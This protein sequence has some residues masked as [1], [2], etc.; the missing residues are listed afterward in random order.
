MA[1]I[2]TCA[3]QREKLKSA[4]STSLLHSGWTD[5]EDAAPQKPSS[6]SQSQTTKAT[7][8]PVPVSDN[9]EDEQDKED[10]EDEEEDEEDAAPLGGPAIEDKNGRGRKKKGANTGGSNL[11][12]HSNE[13]LNENHF[14][15]PAG[16]RLI[17]RMNASV[18]V[19][20]QSMDDVNEHHIFLPG[21]ARL[22]V[23]YA[24]PGT[25]AVDQ[26]SPEE[27]ERIA[28]RRHRK[29]EKK[30]K[31]NIPKQSQGLKPVK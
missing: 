27:K 8:A 17:T 5:D 16:L 24:T 28:E 19:H 12:V 10:E 11:Y 6:Q 7:K 29:K 4:M 18:P 1:C 14:F 20:V 25:G 31:K 22:V 2:T 9:E 21:G 23:P 30:Q 26:R 3:I 15:L 13:A